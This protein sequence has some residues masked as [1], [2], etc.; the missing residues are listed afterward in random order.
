MSV[1]LDD[2]CSRSVPAGKTAQGGK[3]MKRAPEMPRMSKEQILSA[4]GLSNAA[5]RFLVSDYYNSQDA[6]KRCDMQLRHL[7]DE[8]AGELQA[9]LQWTADAN[10]VM[11]NQIQR[12]LAKYAES[13]PIGQWMLDIHGVG[14]VL[15]AGFL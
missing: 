8:A 13:S 9:L 14:P 4:A 1:I 3:A 15:S 5:A 10:A 7:G 6:R 11:E 2:L 12:A